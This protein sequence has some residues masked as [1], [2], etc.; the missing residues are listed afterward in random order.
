MAYARPALIRTKAFCDNEMRGLQLA[1]VSWQIRLEI[2]T[3]A[4]YR[5]LWFGQKH[6]QQ[7]AKL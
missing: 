6:V 4:A 3:A 2:P 5:G 7:A 1:T